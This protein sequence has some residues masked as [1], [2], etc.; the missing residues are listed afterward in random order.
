MNWLLVEVIIDERHVVNTWPVVSWCASFWL[1]ARLCIMHVGWHLVHIWWTFVVWIFC[2]VDFA[3]RQTPA[4]IYIEMHYFCM[5]SNP[6]NYGRSL[7]TLRENR[8]RPLRKCPSPGFLPR[9]GMHKRG[10][11]HHA[12]SVCVSVCVSVTFVHCVKTNKYIFI[13]LT[14]G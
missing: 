4:N 14:F 8:S 11:C 12:V 5:W 1:D 7:Y 3:G 9:D 6:V 2:V 10:L 13:F